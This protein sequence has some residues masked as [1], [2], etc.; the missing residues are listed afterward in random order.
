MNKLNTPVDGFSLGVFRVLF[1]CLMVWESIQLIRKIALNYLLPEFHFTYTLFPFVAPWPGFGLYYHAAAL[2]LSAACLAAGCAYRISSVFFFS[3]FLYFFLLDKA[4]YLNHHYLALLFSFLFVVTHGN[5]G[6]T[7]VKTR[8]TTIP[9]W[10][11]A[12]FQIQTIIV[13]FYGGLAKCNSDWLSGEPMRLWVQQPFA[14]SPFPELAHHAATAY[15]FSYGGLLF[16]LTIGPLLLWRR[17]RKVALIVATAF[18]ITNSWLFSIGVFPWL[19]IATLV[20]FVDAE[21]LRTLLRAPQQDRSAS[22]DTPSHASYLV[23]LFFAGYVSLQLLIPLRG[24]WIPGATSWTE[25]GQRFS[26]RMKLR[27]KRASIAFL[28]FDSSRKQIIEVT[29]QSDLNLFQIFVLSTHPDMII[30]Y[31]KFIRD[32]AHIPGNKPPQ[33]RVKALASLNGRAYQD[34]VD[35]NRDIAAQKDPFLG[36]ADWIVP[37]TPDSSIGQYAARPK[38]TTQSKQRSQK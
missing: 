36:A 26:W 28:L 5:C 31:A 15:A 24:F 37:L 1:G 16:D 11:L 38:I 7:I 27:D 22:C 20:L 4:Y 6:C 21:T 8:K 35:P 17:T 23:T 19:M 32:R 33:V 34:L 14:N 13:Y 30:E 25:E 2:V 12:L 18:H 10:Q 3:S 29:P 9:R